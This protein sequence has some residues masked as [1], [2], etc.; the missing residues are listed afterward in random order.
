[1]PTA[2]DVL[3]LTLDGETVDPADETALR[4]AVASYNAKPNRTRAELP[5]D[6]NVRCLQADE[7]V[8]FVGALGQ[9]EL[10]E[11]APTA[12]ELSAP[13]LGLRA[14]DGFGVHTIAS[15][16]EL[17]AVGGS[18][19]VVP[20]AGVE[21][22]GAELHALIAVRAAA[23]EDVTKA[24][25]ARDALPA[26]TPPWFEANRTHASTV[27]R[28]ALIDSSLRMLLKKAAP[29]AAG[30]P[31]PVG[32]ESW[33]AARFEALAK[34]LAEAASSA[35]AVGGMPGGAPGGGMPGGGMPG[36]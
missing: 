18:L 21:D 25:A 9:V 19:K 29:L 14:L 22:A 26:D 5:D 28:L 1:M 12:L 7:V 31:V 34:E 36:R 33:D 2:L 8:A 4:A 32:D 6:L 3:S 35:P 13:E 23:T 17:A 24:L 11:G 27:G 20:A 16:F 15:G 10:A 30:A